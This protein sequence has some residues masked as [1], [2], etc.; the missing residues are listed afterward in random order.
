MTLRKKALNSKKKKI[1]KKRS[2]IIR[3]ERAMPLEQ[4]G[5]DAMPEV[6]IEALKIA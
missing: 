6:L 5:F 1:I 2:S 3:C 4:E